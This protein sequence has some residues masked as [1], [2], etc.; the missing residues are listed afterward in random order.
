MLPLSPEDDSDEPPSF[1]VLGSC[2]PGLLLPE[3]DVEPDFLP[4][5]LLDEVL[6]RPDD[7][8]AADFFEAPFFAAF[9]GADF[10]E[11]PFFA[12]FFLLAFLGAAFFA[13]FFTDL[14]AAFLGAAFFADFFFAL[15]IV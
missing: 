8:F 13:A 6:L 3:P 12:A 14:F 2:A 9:L 15:A 5:L 10:L 4:P 11:P 1:V 7:L